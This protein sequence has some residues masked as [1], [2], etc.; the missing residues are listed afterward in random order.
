MNDVNT[1]T[2]CTTNDVYGPETRL[3]NTVY[4]PNAANR[5][6]FKPHAHRQVREDREFYIPDFL[7]AE[8]SDDDV[9]RHSAAARH[10]KHLI[11]AEGL[12]GEVR[13]L[14]EV[15]ISSFGDEVD[16]RAMQAEITLRVIEKKL[17]KAQHRIDKHDLRHTNLFLA[18]CDLREKADRR[19]E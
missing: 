11:K 12:L 13:S 19:K 17:R 7:S 15:L 16:S 8:D 9:K 6:L 10:A 3:D 4:L 2:N 18:Y 14:V 5:R 1:A